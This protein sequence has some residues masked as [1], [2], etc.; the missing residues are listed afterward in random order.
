MLNFAIER[1]LFTY[2]YN[3]IAGLIEKE[4]R[5]PE[6]TEALGKF[7][8]G[9]LNSNRDAEFSIEKRVFYYPYADIAGL[10]E[11]EKRTTEALGIS[12]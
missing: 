5:D 4:K 6:A 7:F 10:I 3:D 2:P 12:F 9:S 11:K 1:R 8:P